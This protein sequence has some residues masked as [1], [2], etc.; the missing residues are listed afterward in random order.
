MEIPKLAVVS[1]L[2][3]CISLTANAFSL[4]VGYRGVVQGVGVSGDAFWGY[5][6]GDSIAGTFVFDTDDVGSARDE[7][8]VST[9]APGGPGIDDIHDSFGEDRVYIDVAGP[10][11]GMEIS[12]VGGFLDGD[13]C[14]Q[15]LYEAIV[16]EIDAALLEI[17][18]DEAIWID[19]DDLQG[20]YGTVATLFE[21]DG[22]SGEELVEFSL[23]A[24]HIERNGIV[25]LAEP[26]VLG[27]ICLG[28]LAVGLARRRKAP[29]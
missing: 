10:T 12:N 17:I 22:R 13:C 5:A 7:F 15:V 8:I 27:L 18:G 3:A 9:H 14:G 16:A 25:S 24:L 11:V 20:A 23:T 6:V 19:G 1:T 2:L 29:R 21:L 26:G 28:L 4:S